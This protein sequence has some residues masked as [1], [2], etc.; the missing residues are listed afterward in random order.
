[1][2][3]FNSDF[4]PSPVNNK[5]LISSFINLTKSN[6]EIFNSKLLNHGDYTN[7]SLKLR[8]NSSSNYTSD[9]E[10]ELTDLTLSIEREMEKQQK[11]SE[12]VVP[13]PQPC[14]EICYKCSKKISDRNDACQAMDNIY[15]GDCFYCISCG[16]S[17]KGKPFYNINNNVYCEEDYLY[18]GFLENAEK[19][20]VCGHV[21]VDMI[22]QAIGKSYHPGC[23]RCYN[24]NDCLDGLPFTLDIKN[25]I[26]CIKDYYKK[27][28]PKCASCKQVIIPVDG[29]NETVRVVSMEKD[30]HLECFKCEECNVELNDEPKQRCYPLNNRLLC[31]ECHIKKIEMD[32]FAKIL[33]ENANE[34]NAITVDKQK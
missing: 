26:Y 32:T 16:R 5:P 30:F 23:F 31:Y 17:L 19:C 33:I 15:H 27:Y 25:H 6:K 28:A 2:A 8:S 7:G 10:K 34:N 29:T 9:I 14:N 3:Q 22:L 4:R 11:I 18:S 1:M 21:I 20:S 12:N 13:T 24:C